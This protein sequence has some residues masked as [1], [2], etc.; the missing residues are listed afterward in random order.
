MAAILTDKSVLPRAVSVSF[1]FHCVIPRDDETSNKQAR[2]T[3]K[4]LIELLE[5]HL[6]ISD[7]KQEI[8]VCRVLAQ[9]FSDFVLR[10]LSTSSYMHVVFVSD[11]IFFIDRTFC[12]VFSKGRLVDVAF[13]EKYSRVL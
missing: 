6:A 2:R 13:A 12:H 7:Y 11:S 3:Q 10:D 4:T 9:I 5:S 8:N 1:F